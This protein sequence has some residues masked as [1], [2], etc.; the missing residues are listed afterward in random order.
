[1]KYRLSLLIFLSTL[2]LVGTA[3]TCGPFAYYN[4]NN[5][6]LDSSLSGGNDG[7]PVNVTATAERNGNALGAYLFNGTSSRIDLPSD[8]D[9]G[10]RT[11]CL[12][13]RPD[14]LLSTTQVIFDSDHNGIQFGQTQVLVWNNSGDEILFM[15]GTTSVGFPIAVGEWIHIALVV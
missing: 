3:Q 15:V 4:M 8:F 1:M 5:N 6:M 2:S 7:T 10:N 14:T 13:V 11:W 9:F 12:W